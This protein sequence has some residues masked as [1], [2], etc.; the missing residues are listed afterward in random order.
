MICRLTHNAWNIAI[1]VFLTKSKILRALL[2]ILL[3]TG[4]TYIRGLEL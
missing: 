2:L 1:R 3:V 4:V